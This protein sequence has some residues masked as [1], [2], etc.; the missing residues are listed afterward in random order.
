M[1][2]FLKLMALTRP[3]YIMF[4]ST[5]SELLDYLDYLKAQNGDDWQRLGNYKKLSITTTVN[6]AS[7]YEDHMIYKFK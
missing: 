4:S 1:V 6:R 3:P 7:K 2:D 5:K